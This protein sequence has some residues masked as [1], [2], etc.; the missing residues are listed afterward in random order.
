[1]NPSHAFWTMPLAVFLAGFL[2]V[3]SAQVPTIHELPLWAIML[4]SASVMGL[5]NWVHLVMTPPANA[6]KPPPQIPTEVAVHLPPPPAV[7]RTK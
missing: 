2:P 3:L 4:I 7:P 6:K 1:M 5:S